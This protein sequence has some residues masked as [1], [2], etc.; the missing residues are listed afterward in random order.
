MW[1]TAK[2]ESRLLK[3][4]LPLS[5][6]RAIRESFSALTVQTTTSLRSSHRCPSPK[7]T[8]TCCSRCLTVRFKDQTTAEAATSEHSVNHWILTIVRLVSVRCGDYSPLDPHSLAFLS[9]HFAP[10]RNPPTGSVRATRGHGS[11][12]GPC[13]EQRYPRAGGTSSVDF[14][15]GDRWALVTP[16]SPHGPT[17]S[18]E[19]G[20]LGG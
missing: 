13:Q 11:L 20:R 3:C 1:P 6:A 12:P 14:S 5:S 15:R 18:E 4:S 16:G 17:V 7:R 19:G 2:Q 10:A 9:E 8:R